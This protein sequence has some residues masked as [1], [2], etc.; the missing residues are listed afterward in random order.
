MEN[1]WRYGWYDSWNIGNLTTEYLI[2]LNLKWNQYYFTVESTELSNIT[3]TSNVS[4]VWPPCENWIAFPIKPTDDGTVA[5]HAMGH[6]KRAIKMSS[7]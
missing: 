2:E 5:R 7:T 6:N 4:Y 1:E 3:Q